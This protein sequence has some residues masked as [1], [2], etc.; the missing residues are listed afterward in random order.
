MNGIFIYLII[1]LLFNLFLFLPAYF[2]KTDKLT[3]ASYSIS[4]IILVVVS[5]LINQSL[6]F[7]KL[8]LSGM[9]FFWSLRLGLFLFV[10]IQK[11]NKDT[12]FD[13]IR[14]NFFSFMKFWTLQGL[15]VWI[16]LIPSLFFLTY[17]S[18]VFWIGFF[19]WVMGFSIES[20]ADFQK[21]SFS[22]VNKKK[23]IDSGLW[24]YSRHPNYFG[25]I[26]CWVGIYIFVFPSLM[27]IQKV[28]GL[29]SPLFI[30]FLLIFVSGIPLLEKRA[31]KKWGKDKKYLQYKDSTSILVPFLK[32]KTLK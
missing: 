5:F 3:D 4:F 10:R 25:E 16:I 2:F 13:S 12:R 7:H 27:A 30:S 6:S 9:I 26:L 19:I 24:K 15:S 18:N 11:N 20:I 23:F 29:L 28:L 21:Y 22:K 1:S 8:I 14:S 17:S 31:D 32:I